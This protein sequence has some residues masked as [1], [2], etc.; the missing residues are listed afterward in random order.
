MA[1]SPSIAQLLVDKQQQA[2]AVV[3]AAIA[4]YPDS[5]FAGA[6]DALLLVADDRERLIE[7]L[8]DGKDAKD[9]D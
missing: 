6:L 2:L 9:P 4:A 7:Q 1:F 3:E 8:R 5:D